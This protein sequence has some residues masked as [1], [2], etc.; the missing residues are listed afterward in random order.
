MLARAMNVGR[1]EDEAFRTL[2][3]NKKQA[4]NESCGEETRFSWIMEMILMI[5]QYRDI[6][7]CFLSEHGRIRKKGKTGN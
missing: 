2:E 3:S 7:N 6:V 1:D 5:I 4:A